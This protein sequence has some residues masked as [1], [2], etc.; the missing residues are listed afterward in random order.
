MC[1]FHA[2]ALQRLGECL[3]H[4]VTYPTHAQLHNLAK[5]LYIRAWCMRLPLQGTYPSHSSTTQCY[6]CRTRAV[7]SALCLHPGL[8]DSRSAGV[9]RYISAGPVPTCPTQLNKSRPASKIT[10]KCC[11][12]L[13][14][15]SRASSPCWLGL[16]TSSQSS[17]MPTVVWDSFPGK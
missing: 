9:R 17:D 6:L 4:L 8:P 1:L 11:S 2:A 10:L 13:T 15:H 3:L 14:F 7:S 16:P 12:R 5:I